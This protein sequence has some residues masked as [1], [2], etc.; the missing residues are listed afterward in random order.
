LGRLGFLPVVVVLMSSL[1]F[2]QQLTGTLT[3]TTMDSSGAVVANAKVTLKNELSG[4]T[5]TTVSNSSGYFSIT[6]VQPGSYTVTVD[7][8]GFKAWKQSGI[9]FAQGDN[10][11]LPNISLQV[12]TVNETVEI[13]AGG[14][15]VPLDSAEIST[16]LNTTLVQ[17]IPIVGRDAGELIKLMPGAASTNGITQGN[18]FTD[19][20]VGSNSGPVGAYSINGTQPNGAMAFMLDGANLVD[21]GN[22]GTQIAN[23]NEDMIS[24]VK[25]LTSSYSAE[26]AKGPVIFQAFSKSG[27]ANYHG[28]GYL[29]AR[30]SAL[31]SIDAYTHSQIANGA[32]TAALAA[33]DENFYYMGGNV[34]GPIPIPFSSYNKSH[35]KLF[36]WGG[37]E[38]M[39]QHPAGSIINYNVPT[40]AQLGLD[41]AA[42][43]KFCPSIP[44][45]CGVTNP[46]D[47]TANAGDIPAGAVGAWPFAYGTPFAPPAG[48]YHTDVNGSTTC[49][50]APPQLPCSATVIPVTSFD[51]NGLGLRALYPTPNI[52]PGSGNG[53]N[54]FQFVQHVPQNRWEATG[55]VDYAINDN[56]K[57]SVSY[58]RQI[59][60]AQHPTA[61]WWN[62]P[63]TLPYPSPVVANQVSQ[64]FMS[65]LTHVFSPTT[66]NEFVFTLARY[67]NPNTLS[68]PSKSDR[69]TYNFSVPGLFGH[70]TKQIPN[71]ISDNG[72]GGSFP[73]ITNFSF[74][75]SFNGGNTFGGTKKDPAIYDNFTKVIG[76]HTL[77]VGAYWDT[78][79]NIQSSSAN[80]N[81]IYNFGWGSSSTGNIVDDFLT[82]HAASYTQS[83]AIPVDDVKFHQ[84]SIYAQDS[85]K[86]NRQL[87]L[88][89]GLRFD[90]VGQWYGLPKGIQV[91]DPA[92]YT[93]SP[94]TFD[95]SGTCTA[96]CNPG[97]LYHAINSKIPTSGFVSPLFYYEPRVG[98]AYDVF[99]TGK[100]V[101]RAGFAIFHY[102]IST[103]VCNNN[104]CDGPS[105]TVNYVTPT[106]IN[107]YDI[108]SFV[109]PSSSIENGANIGVSQQGDNKTPLTTDWNVTISQAL[110]WRSVFEISYVGNKTQNIFINGTNSNLDNLNNVATGG[111]FLVDPVTGVPMTPNTPACG[112]SDPSLYCANNPGAYS[113]SASFNPN[114][115][116]PLR[117]YANVYLHTHRGYANYNSLQMAWQKQ[118]GPI[119]FLINYTFSKVLGTRDWNSD[120]GASDGQSNDPFSLKNDYG[121]LAFDHTQIINASY[122]WTL[123]RAFRGNHL[124]DSLV[125][126]WQLS[127]FTTYSMGAPIQPNTGDL[128]VQYPSLTVPTVNYP[129]LPDNSVTLPNGLHSV[130]VNTST[131]L[132]T[133]AYNHLSPILVCDPRHHA[134]GLYFNPNCFAPAPYGQQGTLIWPYVRGPAYFD[135]DL[136]LFKNFQITERQKVQ[137]RIS[138][139][140]FLNHPLPQFGLAGNSDFSLSF[141]KKVTQQVLNTSTNQ[142]DSVDIHSL[143]QTNTNVNTTGK[144]AFKVGQRTL[145]FA[146]KYYF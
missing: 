12:G 8:Q 52:T 72:W 85:F 111:M 87:T 75:G 118:S 21:P 107:G 114:D 99:G 17:D 69:S 33:P 47:S 127:G 65:N 7:A 51:Q 83:N 109:P 125:D 11:N 25:F 73:D 96:N 80:D 90:H 55:K 120:N 16:T 105:G 95:T 30:N 134:S 29:Y 113:P 101:L 66:T 91:W 119:N 132:G 49:G 6:A 102:Q 79:E 78:Q 89:Y 34:G 62:P 98:L 45:G 121:T 100:T 59:E 10:R 50:G 123:P 68:D 115:F 108:S 40:Q 35:N 2:G 36:F 41:S 106:A 67:I 5:R 37:Y 110:P 93:N 84:W 23:I 19:K 56:T 3:G 39:R 122:V 63:W 42:N 82:G 77:K 126:G 22:L 61:I 9:V 44:E 74:D 81:G 138:A 13:T 15:S 60:T 71:I 140:N 129:S 14:G 128:N 18:S 116:R 136:A 145:T 131:W 70:T 137:F 112:G 92:T 94:A 139:V 142:M 117:N 48:T 97:L 103:E 58:T 26:Y 64:V 38:Y 1:S 146:L 124:M 86:A 27:G 144:P 32:T 4:D 104:A 135:S 88:N 20:V 130:G 46:F 31:N 28:E 24:E 76:S 43:S 53:W 133:N 54:N 143:S 57:L 141:D